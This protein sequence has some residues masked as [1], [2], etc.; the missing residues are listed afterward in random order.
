MDAVNV[1]KDKDLSYGNEKNISR[2][3]THIKVDKWTSNNLIIRALW[4]D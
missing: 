3:N 2:S 4:S 1:S